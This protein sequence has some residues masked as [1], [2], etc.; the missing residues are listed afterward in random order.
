VAET[1]AKK[2]AFMESKTIEDKPNDF[3][4]EEPSVYFEPQI[5]VSIDGDRLEKLAVS[6]SRVF[7]E[8][9]LIQSSSVTVTGAA[10]NKYLANTEGTRIRTAKSR[11]TISISATVQADDGMKLSGSISIPG[12]TP[13]DWPDVAE[14][15]ESTRELVE[16]LLA[17]RAA[18]V[19]DSYSG[20]VLFDA[21]ASSSLFLRHFGHGFPGGQRSVGGRT[22]PDD[23]SRK[24]GKRILPRT[25]TVIDDPT[26][27][28]IADVPVMG[29]YVYDDQGVAA[30]AVQLV[31]K[32]RLRAQLMSRNPSREFD[33]S[34]GHGRGSLG[35]RSSVA[36]L[37]V[38]D[39]KGL[40]EADLKTEL[41]EAASDEDLEFAIRI[42]SFGSSGSNAGGGRFRAGGNIPLMIYKVFPDGREELVRGVE[43]G[44]I[45]IKGFKRLL[46][47]GDTAHVLNQVRGGGMTVA[48]PAM[49]FEELDLAKID[50]D[51]DRPPVLDA[52]LARRAAESSK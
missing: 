45:D 47:V 40:N 11:Y 22:P 44:P 16:E 32:G 20:P 10:G 5:D 27:E 51:F 6:L 35:V 46:A 31:E 48:A 18:P 19:L 7:R 3:S 14:L 23:F 29:H 38:A 28:M 49:L 33:R 52:P 42:A 30:R 39:E 8:F 2:K 36:C 34:T 26:R 17:V 9:P 21:Q 15:I 13:A 12:R 50:R 37:I 43:L 4:R 24:I 41:I 1:L 25:M